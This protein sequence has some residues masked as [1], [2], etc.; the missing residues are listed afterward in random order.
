MSRPKFDI[1]KKKAIFFSL[2]L[3]VH[4]IFFKNFGPQSFVICH[5]LSIFIEVLMF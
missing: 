1:E 4:E 2:F 5:F 3:M